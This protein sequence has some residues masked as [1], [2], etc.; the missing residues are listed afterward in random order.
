MRLLPPDSGENRVSLF[1]RQMHI[2]RLLYLFGG[3]QRPL[4]RTHEFERDALDIPKLIKL[5]PRN[6]LWEDII[7]EVII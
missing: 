1:M 6:Y 5:A 2:S 4:L 7:R 3:L